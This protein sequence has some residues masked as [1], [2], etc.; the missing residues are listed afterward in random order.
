MSRAKGTL[1]INYHIGRKTKKSLKYRLKR[2]THEVIRAIKTY[3][4]GNINFIL[5]IGTADGLMLSHIK[6]EFPFAV[7]IGLEYSEHLIA[8]NQDEAIRMVC[9]DAQD[10]PFEED[11]FDIAIA[12]AVIEHIPYPDKM[13]GETYR[14]LKK[15][16]IFILTAPDPFWEHLATMVGHLPD[17]Q[18]NKVMNLKELREIFR[19]FHFEILEAD[20]FMLSPVGMPFEFKIE[21]V[22]KSLGLRCLFANQI[23][24]GR[25]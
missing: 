18:H 23:I 14:V 5:D 16:G 17:E 20:K 6:K 25:K 7:C 13:L 21:R 10:L 2:R 24:V 15:D 8:M 9:G 11:N 22:V 19:K 1:D 3:Y 12:T 4:P